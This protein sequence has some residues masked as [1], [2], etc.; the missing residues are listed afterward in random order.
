MNLA[1]AVAWCI[2][3]PGEGVEVI[4]LPEDEDNYGIATIKF[5]L[6][7]NNGFCFRSEENEYFEDIDEEWVKLMKPEVSFRA[8]MLITPMERELKKFGTKAKDVKEFI[9]KYKNQLGEL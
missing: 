4:G 5:E 8:D 2:T 6:E 7:D 3:N 1:E 9:A